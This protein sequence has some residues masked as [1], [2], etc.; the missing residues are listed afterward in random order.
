MSNSE[1]R[2]Q[3]G[4]RGWW[5]AALHAALVLLHPLSVFLFP[6]RVG[7]SDARMAI[8]LLQCDPVRFRRLLCAACYLSVGAA[9]VV[10]LTFA[11]LLATAILLSITDRGPKA[12]VGWLGQALLG[13]VWACGIAMTGAVVLTLVTAMIAS[14]FRQKIWVDEWAHPA[15]AL[16]GRWPPVSGRP[17]PRNIAGLLAVL[18]STMTPLIAILVTIKNPGAGT[19]LLAGMSGTIPAIWISRRVIARTPAE[20][21]PETSFN[22]VGTN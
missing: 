12:G 2:R 13:I 3:R 6:W 9:K 14:I 5:S 20:C 22:D 15:T 10:M 17:N 21:Y 7:A 4:N 1:H 18:P 11:L 16:D 19:L 8:G